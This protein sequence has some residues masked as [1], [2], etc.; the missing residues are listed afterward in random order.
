MIV[1]AGHFA[2]RGAELADDLGPSCTVFSIGSEGRG[3]DLLAAAE[4]NAAV[5]L[6]AGASGD[7]RVLIDHV[8]AQKCSVQAPKRVHFVTAL[9]KT[10]LGKIDKK[11]LREDHKR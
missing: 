2:A 9:P 8:K 10:G 1:E 6:Q 7:A 5:V 4:V 11:Q 3:I